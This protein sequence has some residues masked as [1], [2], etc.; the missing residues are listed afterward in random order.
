MGMSRP[1]QAYYTADDV[2][3]LNEAN[4]KWWPRYEC[5]YGE[6]LVSPAPAM[7]HQVVIS[8]LH[9][10]MASYIGAQALP[11]MALTAPADISWGRDD[12]TVQPDEFVV[13][14]GMLREAWDTRSWRFIRHLQLAVEVLSPSTRRGDRFTKRQ[15]YQ[16][17][18]VPLYWILDPERETA[19]VWTPEAHFP[20]FER[21]RLVWHPEGAAAPFVCALPELFAKP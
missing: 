1:E 2:R 3:A 20:A 14:I 13:P 18:G 6:L 4:P 11:L 16:R 8:R 17:E 12:V 15:L 7:P 19:E 21:E 10:M 5:V 9:A